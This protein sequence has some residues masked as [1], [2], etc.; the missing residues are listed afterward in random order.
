MQ[1]W[2]EYLDKA[3]KYHGHICG[4]QILGL[5]MSLLGLKLLGYNR[6]DDF[7]DLVVCLESDRC[8]ADAV[9]VVTGLTIGRRRLKLANYG[10]S[11]MTFLHLKSGDAYRISVIDKDRPKEGQ[12]LVE[13]WKAKK[14]EDIF[15]VQRVKFDLAKGDEPGKP[16][17]VVKC[18]KCGDE[19]MDHK[20]KI[21]D[22]QTLCRA[23]ADGPYYA[24]LGDV[25]L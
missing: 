17:R 8:V 12:D 15:R 10:K 18:Q 19:V 11:A 24:V 22:G 9:Y 4:G 2:E 25:E 1:I 20:D 13:F 23:C 6:E 3:T 21:V 7:R 14:D 5:R 16:T